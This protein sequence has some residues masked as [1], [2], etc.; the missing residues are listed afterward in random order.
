MNQITSPK[1]KRLKFLV[2]LRRSRGYGT[3]EGS[4]YVG[5]ENIE[6]WTGRLI[7]SNVPTNQEITPTP[8][9]QEESSSNTFEIGDV[10]FGKLRPYLAKA[11][12]AEFQGRCT[13]EFL[14]MQP[15]EEIES[16]FLLYTCLSRKFVDTIDSS[17]FG[18]KM[19]RADWDFISNLRIDLP[20]LHQQHAITDFL[21]QE[22]AQ[23]D[24]LIVAKERVLDLLNEKRRAIITRAVTRGLNPNVTLRDSGIQWLGKI[25]AHW[26]TPPVYA[27]F[28]VQL[29]KMLDEKRIK[30]THLAPYLRNVDVQWGK[31]NT[32][33]LPEMDFNEEDR[34]RY[35][36]KVG[37]ILICEGGEIGRCAIWK[38]EHFE[39]YYQKALHRLR[40]IG[41][42]DLPEFFVHVM[43][44]IVE[45]GIFSSQSISATIQHLPAEKLRIVRYPAPSIKE[46]HDI[47]EYISNETA[48][49]DSI[50][51]ANEKTIYLLKERRSALIA[52]AVSG[53]IPIKG[54]S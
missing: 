39:C 21:D 17:T 52:A 35:S 23:I 45:G 29:G 8:V 10:L 32:S 27:R 5:L 42:K 12:I 53:Q 49:L 11:W 31:I 13:T 19:P 37:D 30:G 3:M 15:L 2:S 20:P 1:L 38:D 41:D 7:R 25:P 18:A 34:R 51:N 48:K 22:T 36:L 16:R 28:E 9:S 54:V 6:S 43:R 44:A 50:R 26:E 33:D 14:V 46:Q 4:P 47:V 40:P 24:A